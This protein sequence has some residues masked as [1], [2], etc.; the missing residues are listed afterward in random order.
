MFSNTLPMPPVRSPVSPRS[1][2]RITSATDA[3][4]AKK[5]HKVAAFW[6]LYCHFTTL[7]ISPQRGFGGE[8]ELARFWVR[9]FL[10]LKGLR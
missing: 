1:P 8:Y 9:K 7:E 4:A 6:A 10:L 3:L 2:F 5:W